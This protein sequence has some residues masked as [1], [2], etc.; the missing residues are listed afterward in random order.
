M[1]TFVKTRPYSAAGQLALAVCCGTL[2]GA[3]LILPTSAAAQTA[4][5]S[6]A[7]TIN[8]S[9]VSTA[10]LL[11]EIADL[12]SMT[13]YPTP[14]YLTKQF[15]SYDRASTAA[16]KPG[17]F[18]NADHGKY[19]RSEE[20][21]GR[22]EHVMMDATGPGAVVH[23][24]SANPSGVLRVYLDGSATPVLEGEM[25]SFMNGNAGP[26]PAPLSE[27]TARGHN[28]YFPI[29]YASSCKITVESA[30]HARLYYTIA[31][32]AYEAGTP[33]QS[34][35]REQLDTLRPQIERAATRL[36]TPRGEGIWPTEVRPFTVS[37]A[38]G[39]ST[40]LA[41]LSGAKA[42][43]QFLVRLRPE[44]SE[45]AL[46]S[47][48][49]RMSF[50][51][52]QTV[53]APLGDF[54]GTAPGP[55]PFTSLPLGITP[56]REMWSHWVMPFRR[57]ARIQILNMG[58]EAVVLRGQIGAT[59]YRWTDASMYFYAGYIGRYDVATRPM[60]DLNVLKVNGQGV[61][62]GLAYAV[63]NPE[64]RWWGEGDEKITVDGEAF[65]SWFGTGTEDYFGYAWCDTSEFSHA[66]HAQPRAEGPGGCAGGRGHWGRASNNRF[67]ILDRIPFQ[68]SLNF[69]ME[70]QHWAEAKVNVASVAYWY[71][72]SGSTHS[73]APLKPA[74]L[75][76]R[77]MPEYT[78]PAQ[79]AGAIEG[80]SMRVITN[81]A[82]AQAVP[83]EGLPPGL[84]GEAH[85]WW[86]YTPKPG[87]RLVLGFDAPRAG[88][89]RVV[90][91]FV[92]ARDYGTMQFSINGKTAG[93]PID[94][95][96]QE[97]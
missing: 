28:L 4:T 69:D 80:E 67:H 48:V 12:A 50:D 2:T 10:N 40:T 52:K 61:F 86:H 38:P 77:V 43:T 54:F 37:L 6:R 5:T 70:L 46:R 91:R 35:R 51:G 71:A 15:S 65:P 27:I 76:V 68:R 33:V 9:T 23:I 19:V 66:F 44:I 39:A 17:W 56:D 59:P 74:D 13:R 49:V 34:F 41:D 73:F 42:I 30:D 62:A 72:K 32:R 57:A 7:A 83:Q 84:S 16:D 63:D 36:S 93:A 82:T 1:N 18:A 79:V 85:L 14:A 29:P 90:G 58:R 88:T 45:A 97:L 64:R 26:V 87:D 78:P 95:Y 22:T 21:N 96:D 94:F 24:W 11:E 53:E 75:V 47:L 3:G 31:Y 60:P 8:S 92:K 55:N 89:Y 81:T 25:V 20:R